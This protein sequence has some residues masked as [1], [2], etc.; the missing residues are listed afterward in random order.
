[1]ACLYDVGPDGQARLMGPTVVVGSTT[2]TAD[3]WDGESPIESVTFLVD[4]EIQDV[5]RDP[6]YTFTYD[7]PLGHVGPRELTAVAE[8]AAGNEAR[9]TVPITVHA[10]LG[11][12]SQQP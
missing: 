8:D 6:P 1:M 12:P 2:V 10:G 9:D 5:D 3:A 4:D 7:P 11:S